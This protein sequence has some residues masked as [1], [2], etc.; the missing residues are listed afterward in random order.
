MVLAPSRRQNSKILI[1]IKQAI[2][3]SVYSPFLTRLTGR[4]RLTCPSMRCPLPSAVIFMSSALMGLVAL[5]AVA[6]SRLR[7][8]LGFIHASRQKMFRFLTACNAEFVLGTFSLIHCW[9]LGCK[10]LLKYDLARPSPLTYFNTLLKRLVMVPSIKPGV[11]IL[12][13]YSRVKVS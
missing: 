3:S 9:C 2:I 13:S 7:C 12:S 8:S 4:P 6:T 1:S 5:C 10:S 11:A